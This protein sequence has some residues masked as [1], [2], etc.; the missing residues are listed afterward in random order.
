MIVLQGECVRDYYLLYTSRPGK[1]T[2]SDI[3]R[4]ERDGDHSHSSSIDVKS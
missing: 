3:K 1:G 2:P 4:P